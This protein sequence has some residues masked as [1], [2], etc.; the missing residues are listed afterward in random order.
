MATSK[1]LLSCWYLFTLNHSFFLEFAL[2]F[3]III[4]IVNWDLSETW[5]TARFLLV[6]TIIGHFS[7]Y[8]VTYDRCSILSLSLSL[9]KLL[10][11]KNL[12][13]SC[14]KWNFLQCAN[15]KEDFPVC[16][17]E[18]FCKVGIFFTRV[19]RDLQCRM[20]ASIKTEVW[21]C[22]SEVG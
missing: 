11:N 20:Y 19:H 16:W 4:S 8:Y 15:V 2:V 10:Q 18:Y 12:T 17:C 5:V 7:Q 3:N 21:V 9:W 14:L 6:S 22:W 13:E 1:P